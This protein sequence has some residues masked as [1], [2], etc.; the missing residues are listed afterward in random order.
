MNICSRLRAYLAWKWK[1][2]KITFFS[3]FYNAHFSSDYVFDTLIQP[4]FWFVDHFTAVLGPIFVF[5]VVFLTSTAV[6]IAYWIGLPYYLEHKN[7]C[8]VW[9]LIVFG[10]YLLINV[11]FHF[12]MALT[13]SP[14]VPPS[15]RILQEVTS[16]C[17]KCIAPKPPRTHHCSVCNNCMLKMDH[18]CPWLNNCIGHYNH[19]HFFLYMTFMVIGCAFLMSF[20]FEVFYEEFIEHW[21][22]AGGEQVKMNLT[23]KY[24]DQNFGV[25]NRRSLVFYETFMTSACFVTL[26]ALTLWHARLIH[27]GQTSIEAH[28]NKSETKRMAELGKSYRNP[29]NFGPWFNWYLFL[30][31]VDGRGWGSVFFPSAHKPVGEGLSWNS[32]YSCNINWTYGELQLSKLS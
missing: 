27:A 1:V 31:L 5:M 30:G 4:A 23:E 25:F 32:V 16:I 20:G 10:H 9:G 13:I 12:L 18:H 17:K 21:G 14:G 6:F 15:D 8:F 19:R 24:P 22:I 29:Y 11:I 28:I 2:T 3:M 7:I 26:G